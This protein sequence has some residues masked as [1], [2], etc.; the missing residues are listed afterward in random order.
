MRRGDGDI[1]RRERSVHPPTNQKIFKF[2]TDARL[3]VDIKFNTEYK[4]PFSRSSLFSPLSGQSKPT[5]PMKLL[6]FFI[7]LV[8]LED[9]PNHPVSKARAFSVNV[10]KHGSY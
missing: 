1:F 5:K 8:S 6:S 7:N 2:K 9:P 4:F 3:Q 10:N